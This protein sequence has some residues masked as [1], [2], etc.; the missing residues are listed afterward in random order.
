VKTRLRAP[1]P[2]AAKRNTTCPQR[3]KPTLSGERTTRFGSSRLRELSIVPSRIIWARTSKFALPRNARPQQPAAIGNLVTEG[4][5]RDSIWKNAQG[6]CAD[7]APLTLQRTR[8]WFRDLRAP[9]SCPIPVEPMHFRHRLQFGFLPGNSK[10]DRLSACV[11]FAGSGQLRARSPER[12]PQTKLGSRRRS[13]GHPQAA[14]HGAS[15]LTRYP[16]AKSLLFLTCS[17]FR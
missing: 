11:G 13:V 6:A 14:A 15:C 17:G 8:Y 3:V 16:E 7:S 1:R 10:A 9:R 12:Q 4:V 2:L 5:D